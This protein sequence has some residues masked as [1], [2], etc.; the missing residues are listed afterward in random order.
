MGELEYQ[1]HFEGDESVDIEMALTAV[2]SFEALARAVTEEYYTLYPS[3]FREPPLVNVRLKSAED[4]SV[5]LPILVTLASGIDPVIWQQMLDLFLAAINEGPHV[6][7][8]IL[9]SPVFNVAAGVAGNWV[10]DAIKHKRVPK[11]VGEEQSDEFEIDADQ[12]ECMTRD[13]WV[14]AVA[15]NDTAMNSFFRTA[16]AVG[17]D[18]SLS[19]CAIEKRNGARLVGLGDK[20][21]SAEE[22][23]M[24]SRQVKKVILIRSCDL[25]FCS[26]DNNGP[27]V[28]VFSN[29]GKTRNYGVRDWDLNSALRNAV[30]SN[31]AIR[32]EVEGTRVYDKRHGYYY[33]SSTIVAILD[34]I[35]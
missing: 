13:V 1:L 14:G 22:L 11:L 20:G 17:K 15:A 24:E 5:I 30:E 26:D 2:K 21:V 33:R 27:V 9:N 35:E 16:K 25:V 12:F 29:D 4:G 34:A 23:A 7:D 31:Y 28:Q 10:Y 6:I 18:E 3:D 8:E 32:V 19:S